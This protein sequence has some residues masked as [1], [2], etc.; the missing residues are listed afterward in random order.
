M[1]DW[2]GFGF[3]MGG[4]AGGSPDLTNTLQD[5]EEIKRKMQQTIGQQSPTMGAG[6]PNAP[7][8]LQPAVTG[9]MGAGPGG[10]GPMQGPTPSGATADMNPFQRGAYNMGKGD[11]PQKL[12]N[13]MGS[14][15][16]KMMAPTPAPTPP[17]STNP[18]G[19]NSQQGMQQMSA[20]GQQGMMSQHQRPQQ[21]QG[22]QGPP[23][24]PFQSVPQ[25]GDPRRPDPRQLGYAGGFWS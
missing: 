22:Q 1:M 18:Q 2:G 8:G 9:Q 20:M 19:P 17:Q 12:G 5:I 4:A 3:D 13:I 16:Q 10:Q 25:G 11:N 14:T 6:A 24:A 21:P 15:A 7:G 23:Q